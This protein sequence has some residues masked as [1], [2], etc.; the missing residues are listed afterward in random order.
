MIEP[1]DLT[2]YCDA[3]LDVA[4][5][6]DFAPN[7]LQVEGVRPIR[8]LVSGV[9][10]C[11]ALIDAAC[12]PQA[13][14]LLV[15]H[16]WFWRGESPC[17]TGAKGRR[18]RALMGSGMSLIAYHLPLDA[19][20]TLGNNA[21]LAVRLGILDAQPTAIGH[22]VVWCGRLMDAL[23]PEVW[24]RAVS[25]RLGRTGTLVAADDRPVQR[26]AWCT[27]GGQGYLEAAAALG[28]DAFLSGEI[29]E[30]TTHAA[31]ELGVSF[32]AAGHHATERFGVQALGEHLAERFTLSH[33][34]LE[35]D[36]PA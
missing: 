2:A 24:A 29:S 16:G 13:D 30:Q 28:I 6:T 27:G 31:R 22:G 9:T 36:N 8:R 12:D 35:I 25:E 14:A 19:H 1:Q 20:L 17:L 23:P 33:R 5:F 7:G 3:L 18:V 11:A 21:T 15:H 34:Y 32:L 10:A 4:A 26:V